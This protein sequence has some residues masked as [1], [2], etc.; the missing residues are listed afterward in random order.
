MHGLAYDCIVNMTG[1]TNS[2]A[3]LMQPNNPQSSALGHGLNA[4]ITK[5]WTFKRWSLYH[6][7][8]SNNSVE[9]PNHDGGQSHRA[10]GSLQDA[11]S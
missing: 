7:F 8:I 4:C 2:V 11:M 5:R 3:A 6:D 1:K 9:A 10:Y